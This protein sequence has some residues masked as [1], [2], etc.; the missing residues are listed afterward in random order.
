MGAHERPAISGVEKQRVGERPTVAPDS[1]KR[2]DVLQPLEVEEIQKSDIISL[3]LI[4][5]EIEEISSR[6]LSSDQRR[7]SSVPV[8]VGIQRPQNQEEVVYGGKKYLVR[9]LSRDEL[10]AEFGHAYGADECVVRED[11]SPRVKNFVKHH[12]LYHLRDTSNFGGWIGREIRANLIPGLK[13]I[14]R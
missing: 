6:Q 2:I 1:H 8:E 10:G 4:R 7:A 13:E 9:Y 5:Q 12:E 3:Q 14:P 11:L